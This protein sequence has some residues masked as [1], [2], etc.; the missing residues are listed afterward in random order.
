METTTPG[1][2]PARQARSRRTAQAIADAA[3]SL[4]AERSF[5][6]LSVADLARAAGTSVGGFYARYRDKHAVLETIHANVLDETLA[7][8]ETALADVDA[9]NGTARDV[10][11]ACIETMV[12]QFVIHRREIMQ[13]RRHAGASQS[14][15]YRKRVAA[16]NDRVHS[17]V[18]ELLHAR[19]AEMRHPDPAFAIDFG[20]FAASA[21]ARE[22]VLS[23]AHTVYPIELDEA[24][25]VAELV[26]QWAAYL[27]IPST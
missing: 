3:R 10:I 1:A 20:M 12:R 7:A 27:R 11:H 24:R 17:R 26:A 25:L 18:R 9:R 4:L 14:G 5:H 23:G 16:F 2:R 6:E 15:E 13:I 22:A 8:F 19:I 21:A